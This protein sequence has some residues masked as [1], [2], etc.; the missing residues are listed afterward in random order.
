MR[1]CLHIITISSIRNKI[2]G[3]ANKV[4]EVDK[5]VKGVGRRLITSDALLELCMAV[6][7]IQ[8]SGHS[9]GAP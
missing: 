7:G 4:E 3:A 2:A 9:C 1:G 8:S 6:Y 5:A